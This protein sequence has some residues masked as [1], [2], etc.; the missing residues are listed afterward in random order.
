VPYR[1]LARAD[2][3]ESKRKAKQAA[4]GVG[5]RLRKRPPGEQQGEGPLAGGRTAKAKK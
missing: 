4:V 2:S 1:H 5:V 3:Y